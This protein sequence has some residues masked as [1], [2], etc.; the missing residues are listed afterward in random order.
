MSPE[1]TAPAQPSTSCSGRGLARRSKLAVWIERASPNRVAIEL[2]SLVLKRHWAPLVTLL[3]RKRMAL[4]VRHPAL[5]VV[6]AGLPPATE[7][8]T[9]LHEA[10]NRTS[11]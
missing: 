6:L 9:N 8:F 4:I 7:P 10:D 11:P 3:G 2:P 5:V 1:R